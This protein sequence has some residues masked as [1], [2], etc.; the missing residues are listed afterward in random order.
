MKVMDLTKLRELAG[1][2]LKEDATTRNEIKNDLLSGRY[3]DAISG[4]IDDWVDVI[5]V[6]HEDL[7][8]SSGDVEQALYKMQKEMDKHPGI[9]GWFSE[10]DTPMVMGGEFDDDPDPADVRDFLI[11]VVDTVENMSAVGIDAE[12][13][14][15][16]GERGDPRGWE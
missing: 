1:L 4:S 11:R 10:D 5:M 7:I 12:D 13:D 14:T 9:E 2:P 15:Q 16:Y 3:R 8:M 6:G